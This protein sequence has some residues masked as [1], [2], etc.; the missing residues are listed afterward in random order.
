MIVVVVVLELELYIS[1]FFSILEFPFYIL[2][3]ENYV[4]G[5]RRMGGGEG[6]KGEGEWE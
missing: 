4:E 2:N 5:K 1:Y 3:E 6:G